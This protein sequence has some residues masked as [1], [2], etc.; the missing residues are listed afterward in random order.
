M[1]STFWFESNHRFHLWTNLKKYLDSLER[2]YV[3]KLWT[4]SWTSSM[5]FRNRFDIPAVYKSLRQLYKKAIIYW[6]SF[7]SKTSILSSDIHFFLFC[8]QRTSREFWIIYLPPK[9]DHLDYKT[10]TT[11]QTICTKFICFADV[12]RRYR[13]RLVLNCFS[14]P[15]MKI[16]FH[17]WLLVHSAQFHWNLHVVSLALF[18]RH[19]L[20]CLAARELF[21]FF[22]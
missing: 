1:L 18:P 21:R 19:R 7:Q 11:F 16:A 4:L 20:S 8:K 17:F 9:C 15:K 13:R 12:I 3:Q 14:S 22:F 6:V 5:K 2:I 10:N